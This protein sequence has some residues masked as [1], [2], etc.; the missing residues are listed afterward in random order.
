[1]AASRLLAKSY[2]RE[3]WPDIPPPFALLTQHSRD[4]AESA[5]ALVDHIGKTALANAG[6][7]FSLCAWPR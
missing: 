1:M 4:V 6:L 5:L 2:S 3:K 7:S